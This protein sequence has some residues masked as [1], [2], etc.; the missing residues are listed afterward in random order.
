MCTVVCDEYHCR[1]SVTWAAMSP[2]DAVCVQRPR[3]AAQSSRAKVTPT[4]CKWP[5]SRRPNS[6]QLATK[7]GGWQIGQTPWVASIGGGIHASYAA[8]GQPQ[9]QPIL[10]DPQ[11][12][13]RSTPPAPAAPGFELKVD[14]PSAKGLVDKRELAPEDQERRLTFCP[15]MRAK[16]FCRLPSCPFVH[17]VCRP[18][19]EFDPLYCASAPRC[20]QDVQCRFFAVLG[21]CPHGDNCIYS[22]AVPAPEVTSAIN[23]WSTASPSEEAEGKRET[24][25]SEASSDEFR[26]KS[27]RS[28][29]SVARP[30]P[31]KP[32][33]PPS[34]CRPLRSRSSKQKP[35]LPQMAFLGFPPD[36]GCGGKDR[37]L[38][39]GIAVLD[40]MADRQVTVTAG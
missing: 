7:R 14:I 29:A 34:S 32:A 35:T 23:A 15:R 17:E 28:S 25:C 30:R 16:G 5:V 38:S 4:R 18:R 40:A 21:C 22:H 33:G 39:G 13:V 8:I 24:V 6:A 27:L 11:R 3:S 19:R 37:P 20:C 26:R 2:M 12:S 9:V 10:A 36:L 1:A 31:A